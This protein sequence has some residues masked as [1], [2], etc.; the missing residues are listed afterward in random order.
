[1]RIAGREATAIALLLCAAPAFAQEHAARLRRRKDPSRKL[2]ARQQ[3]LHPTH[4][5]LALAPVPAGAASDE[6][7][8]GSALHAYDLVVATL[9]VRANERQRQA[10]LTSWAFPGARCSVLFA[11]VYANK[12]IAEPGRVSWADTHV[13]ELT[14]RTAEAYGNLPSK[15]LG[16][17]A[18][19]SRHVAF[20]YLL[21]TD[22]DSF[23]CV[24]GLLAQLAPLPRAGL[25]WGKLRR[26]GQP[27]MTEGKW[28][29][30]GFVHL[31]ASPVYGVYAFGAGYILSNDLVT[32]A[33][34]R[35]LSLAPACRVED[36]LVGAAIVGTQPLA[37]AG[38]DRAGAA[39]DAPNAAPAADVDAD[40]LPAAPVTPA[41]V[42][43][44]ARLTAAPAS[45]A[46]SARVRGGGGGSGSAGAPVLTRTDDDEVPPASQLPSPQFLGRWVA[47]SA[48]IV[49][50]VNTSRIKD[51]DPIAAADRRLG[52]Q[53][54]DRLCK[55]TAWRQPA[56]PTDAAARPRMA[57]NAGGGGGGG[58][59]W[60][61]ARADRLTTGAGATP[62]WRAA[63]E[64][65]RAGGTREGAP[66]VR[67]DLAQLPARP[68]VAEAS[69]RAEPTR[70]VGGPR[71]LD[72]LYELPN[73][74]ASPRLGGHY[75]LIHRIT[76]WLVRRCALDAGRFC[77]EY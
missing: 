20:K 27:V 46:R 54:L 71:R 42:W 77:T 19:I 76:P 5:A 9:S 51:R 59:G 61:R 70:V 34:L 47:G 64:S 6:L 26:A 24:G 55:R 66:A 43:Q 39:R 1:M 52:K 29:D 13:L 72:G 2:M 74:G 3:C 18:W 38:L 65:R 12:T 25:Y 45:D 22:D 37:R 14:V 69:H 75:L 23:A 8:V 4:G 40:G 67:I 21:K 7:G 56:F 58:G 44:P 28:R 32:A 16:A 11:I 10:L 73:V 41:L 49:H 15:V 53:G 48:T 63:K 50:L 68:V 36:A 57:D 31:L 35:M 30:E 60:W 17:F 62:P 33:A